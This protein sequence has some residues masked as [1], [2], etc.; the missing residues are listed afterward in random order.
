MP[1]TWTNDALKEYESGLDRGTL[2]IRDPNTG[3]YDVAV[4]WYGLISVQKTPEGAEPTDLYSNNAKYATLLSAETF[5]GTIEAYS[6]PDE[7]ILCDGVAE[8]FAGMYL[9]QQPRAIFGLAF[10]SR[11]G[12]A[13]GGDVVTYKYH[14]IWGCKA[15]PSEVAVNTINESPEAQTFS[16]DFTTVPMTTTG[17][18]PVSEMVIDIDD[19]A[20]TVGLDNLE[21]SLWGDAPNLL[22]TPD[23]VIAMLTAP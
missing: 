19:V 20:Y 4:P 14:L 6:A 5:G 18:N 13:Q 7:F 21:T 10:R 1:I 11:V 8:P 17:H 15:Q 23:A 12:D 9:H 22:P 16:W 2:F 3:I